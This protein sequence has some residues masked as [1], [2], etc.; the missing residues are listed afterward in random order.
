MKKI[1][2]PVVLAGALS[3]GLTGC[4]TLP[5]PQPTEKVVDAPA[6][7]EETEESTDISTDA[8]A[9]GVAQPGDV[10]ENG[11]WFTYT[12]VNYDDA[13]ATIQARLLSSTPA[14]PA[15]VDLLVAEIPQLK[16][17]NVVL[18]QFEQRKID[19][20][21]IAFDADY[22]SFIPATVTGQPAQEVSVIGWDDCP[23]ESF[24]KEFDA[25]TESITSC[26]VGAWVDG[27]DQIGGILYTGPSALDDNPFSQYGGE[28]VFLK[29]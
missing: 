23:S 16:G 19:G 11:E 22:T 5:T 20:A 8:T 6:E 24:S 9:G 12:F 13:S 29:S 1:V 10:I 28:P 2:L 14:T 27:G 26:V 21:E 7:T 3:L 4:I 17:Y 18:L 15:Q 25:G